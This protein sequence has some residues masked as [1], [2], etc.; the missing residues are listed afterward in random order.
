MRDPVV[1]HISSMLRAAGACLL[2]MMS[3]G[4]CSREETPELWIIGLDGADWDILEPLIARGDL[5]NLARLR[6][7]GAY[8]R[9]QSD[10]PMLSPI[11]WTSIATGKT[12]DL[13]GVTWFMSDA[14]DGTKIPVSSRNRQVR[15]LWNIADERDVSSGV[16]GWWATWPAE[17]I[18]GFMVSDY[19]GWHSFG[20]TGR[21]LDVPGKTWPTNLVD[22]ATRLFGSP[23]DVSDQ[24]LQRMVHLPSD[25]LGFDAAAGPFGGPLPHL[26]QAVATARGYTDLTKELLE[27]DRPNLLCL[28]YEGTDA[29]EHL[30][31]SYASPRLPW[32]SAEDHAA[33]KD[34]IDQY[35]KWQDELLGELL[36]LRGSQTTV[37]IVSD[38]G[39]RTGDERLKE[40]EFSVETADASHMTDGIV[41]L[42]GPGIKPASRLGRATIYDVTP[43]ALHLLGLP[44]ASDMRGR[45]LTEALLDADTR[46]VQT[47]ATFE[48]GAWD[49]GDD[50]VAD[51]EAGVRME[52]MLRSLGYI[53]GGD[54]TAS[55]ESLGAN[56]EQ[57][58]NLA[59]VLRQQ[60]RFDEAIVLLEE[61]LSTQPDH[62]PAQSNLARIFAE[63]GRMEEAVDL[64]RTLHE[65]QPDDLAA[66]EDYA[67]ALG[68]SERPQDALDVYEKGLKLDPQWVVGL[69]G[70]G[71][72]L[73]SLD[74]S[75]EALRTLDAAI[76]ADPR[77]PDTHYYR[78]VVLADAERFE[79]AKTELERTLKLDPGHPQAAARLGTLFEATGQAGSAAA[80]I[81]SALKSTPDD[82]Q[83]RAQLGAIQLRN[84]AMQ[85]A[86]ENLSFA[87]ARLKDDLGVQ[88]NY[89][90]ALANLGRLDEAAQAFER[91]VAI[92]PKASDAFATL[93]SIYAQMGQMERAESRLK[94]AVELAP[95]EA[96]VQ[97]AMGDFYHRT[98]QLSLARPY[99]EKAVELDDTVGRFQY[100]LAMLLGTQG[101]EEAALAMIE[102][103]REL[104]P[105][106]PDPTQV[107]NPGP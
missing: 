92:D 69:A 70:K 85:P 96:G 55:G 53:S 15:A 48:T 81:E 22:D 10:E 29:V 100:Q 36:A 1:K 78:G 44:V 37:M 68:R 80:L 101:D 97:F 83:L 51:P 82:P 89:G 42:H 16:V 57:N 56:V 47:V 34:V 8:G 46:P 102:R 98:R 32:V 61:V 27:R 73:H 60:G 2:L 28:Y 94:Q 67:L 71:F 31:T 58:V 49:R 20:V 24:L 7:Q 52:E 91:V 76:E 9:L 59:V 40:D 39:F 66:L 11:L 104:D 75:E 72:S 106:L 12:A 74:R 5:P 33:F 50:I 41:V 63:A 30:F 99:Y 38:H 14:P 79:E 64:Y 25:R 84:G 21:E 23:D 62:R 77:H 86:L 45:A 6:S 18:K 95:G 43:T 54:G 90:F 93:G 103:A 87:A 13:H 105:S 4:G 3:L 65:A 17:P 19:V 35:W 26:R 88:G 107:Q